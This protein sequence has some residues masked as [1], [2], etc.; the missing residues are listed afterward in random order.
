[1]PL[2][3]LRCAL[4]NPQ[5]D[6]RRAGYR[7][8]VPAASTVNRGNGQAC[9]RLTFPCPRRTHTDRYLPAFLRVGAL[10]RGS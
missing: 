4:A 10:S 9:F 3:T 7:R 1:M 8:R 5:T 2:S 6:E